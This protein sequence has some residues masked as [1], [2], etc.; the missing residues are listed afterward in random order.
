MVKMFYVQCAQRVKF[1]K[2]EK[3]KNEKN[4]DLEIVNEWT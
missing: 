1:K 3:R 4:S 2:K